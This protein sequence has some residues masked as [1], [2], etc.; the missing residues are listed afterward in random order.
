MKLSSKN[1]AKDVL[2]AEQKV[3]AKYSGPEG[4][5]E[6]HME[7]AKKMGATLE[8]IDPSKIDFETIEAYTSPKHTDALRDFI[9]NPNHKDAQSAISDLGYLQRRLENK[10]TLLQPEK[11]QLK[12]VK[13]AKKYIQENMYKDKEGRVIPDLLEE[14]Q[15]IQKGYAK[16]VIP[17]TKNQAIQKYKKGEKLPGELV[18]YLSKGKFATQK[19]KQHRKIGM[20]KFIKQNKIPLTM[21]GGGAGL[22]AALQHLLL[23]EPKN[24]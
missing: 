22:Y 13:D 15:K 6:K 11:D 1:I 5:Y 12:A 21:A 3:K 14:H 18:D 7:K 20:R 2:K 4:L 16:D 24:E 10:A 8:H 17:Y 9:K 19:G 23:G